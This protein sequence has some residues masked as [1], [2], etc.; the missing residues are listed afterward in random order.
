[1]TMARILVH[2]DTREGLEEKITLHWRHFSHRKNLDYEGVPFRCRRCHKDGDLYK[3]CPLLSSPAQETARG[4]K[5]HL[6]ED[7]NGEEKV[8]GQDH[9]KEVD[10]ASVQPTNTPGIPSTS[11]QLTHSRSA[12]AETPTSGNDPI[13]YSLALVYNHVHSSLHSPAS[14]TNFILD[15]VAQGRRTT[16]KGYLEHPSPLNLFPNGLAFLQLQGT[17]QPQEKI[18]S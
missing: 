13:S 7:L 8:S 11:P 10:G 12:M 16:I 1:M 5:H 2:L 6:F 14:H 17:S 3:D 15:D 4:M 18:G 9:P